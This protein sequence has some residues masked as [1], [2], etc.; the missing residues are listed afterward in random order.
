MK[1]L[2]IS[3]DT[4]LY[5]VGPD[6]QAGPLPAIFYL[7]LSAHD[8]LLVDPFNQPVKALQHMPLRIFSLDLPEHESGK[9]PVSALQTWSEQLLLGVPLIEQF[10]RRVEKGVEFLLEKNALLPKQLGIMGLSR[11]GFLATHVAAKIPLF[12]TILGFAPMTTLTADT[13]LSLLTESLVGKRVRFYMGNLDTRVGTRACFEFIEALCQM[14]FSQQI[15]SPQ[16]ELILSPSIGHLGHGTSP[17]IFA[18]GAL[19]LGKKIS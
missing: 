19:W 1:T 17:E 8:T 3:H 16:V 15:R 14:N 10:V 13:H 11:G 12:H 4:T 9:P 7:A 6:L 5:Y 2:H 18:Q